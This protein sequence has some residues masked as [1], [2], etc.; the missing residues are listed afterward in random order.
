M[1][2]FIAL[3]SVALG[4]VYSDLD[5]GDLVGNFLFPL[6]FIAGITYSSG[7]RGWLQS[8]WGL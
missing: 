8:P 5:S 7:L 6:L 3:F 4:V 2:K 1:D